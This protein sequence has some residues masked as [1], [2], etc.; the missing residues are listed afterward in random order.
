MDAPRMRT[1][2]TALRRLVS[3]LLLL[4]VISIVTIQEGISLSSVTVASFAPSDL[5]TINATPVTLSVVYLVNVT[6][7]PYFQVETDF[8]VKAPGDVFR[9]IGHSGSTDGHA[10]TTYYP[11]GAGTYYWYVNAAWDYNGTGW[12]N[13]QRFPSTSGYWTFTCQITTAT[14]TSIRY[15]WTTQTVTV[16][17]V[18]SYSYLY[19]TQNQYFT[20]YTTRTMSL[21]STMRLTSTITASTTGFATTQTSPTTTHETI[22]STETQQSYG[23]ITITQYVYVESYLAGREL[24]SVTIQAIS[25]GSSGIASFSKSDEH[26]VQRISIDV[27]NNVANVTLTIRDTFL[28]ESGPTDAK[29][30]KSFDIT[31]TN[32]NDQDLNSVKI[33]FKVDKN[34]LTSNQVQEND[35]S[36]YRYAD[37]TWN[38]LPT[39][40]FGYDDAYVYYEATS[41]GLSSY[42]I[43]G[44]TSLSLQL[45]WLTIDLSPYSSLLPILLVSIVV[46]ATIAAI[47]LW[48]KK[49]RTKKEDT[50]YPSEIGTG[51]MDEKILNYITSH[52]GAISLG[53]A[54]EDLGVSTGQ[55]TGTIEKLK[56]SGQLKAN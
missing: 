25:S 5:T 32:L 48:R 23:T 31:A 27:T 33:R 53:Q 38:K 35:V 44:K 6:G 11:P 39:V 4:T 41:P 40:Q 22:Y 34:W 15:S 18:T 56:A 9:P 3:T 13:T 16:G 7:V 54:S 36:L 20:A 14:S 21:T 19:L 45:P 1:D 8:Y 43:A 50:E 26:G 30:Y 12:Q 17:A 46:L 10:S 24:E 42:V 2:K 28:K 51:Q 49:H 52:R 55:L 37:G 47:V 29:N